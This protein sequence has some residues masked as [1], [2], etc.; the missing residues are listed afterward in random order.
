MLQN[1]IPSNPGDFQHALLSSPPVAKALAA[2]TM[3]LYLIDKV[4]PGVESVLAIK[5]TNTYGAHSYVW[6]V[7]TAGFFNN[8]IGMALSMAVVFL[9]MGRFLVP[10]WGHVEFVRFI[11]FSNLLSGIIVFFTQIAYYM[12][13]FNY[14]QLELP[15]SG[16]W[17]II[18]ALLVAIKQRLPDEPISF[19]NQPLAGASSGG[20]MRIGFRSPPHIHPVYFGRL[21]R[22]AVPPI[23]AANQC[24]R[25]R[26]PL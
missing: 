25:T 11:L 16:G 22:L 10:A 5:A 15:I 24:G 23:S 18:A 17:P 8:N 20:G 26:R 2:I 9:V 14:K 12:C 1:I 13:T 3:V 6:N 7:M 21:L 19:N 4:V